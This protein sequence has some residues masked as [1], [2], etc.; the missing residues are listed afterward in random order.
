MYV[1]MKKKKK[2]MNK[3]LGGKVALKKSIRRDENVLDKLSPKHNTAYVLLPLY[4]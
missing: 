4:S 1:R 2:E 3:Y